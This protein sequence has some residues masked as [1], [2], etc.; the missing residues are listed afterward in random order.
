MCIHD[1]ENGRLDLCEESECLFLYPRLVEVQRVSVYV[2]LLA[3]EAAFSTVSL[4]QCAC[5]T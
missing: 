5:I 2:C 1:A 4:C 3:V